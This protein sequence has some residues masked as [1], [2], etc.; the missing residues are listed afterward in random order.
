MKQYITYFLNYLQTE[1]DA[2]K[3]TIHKYRADLEKLFEYLKV[4][5]INEID[6]NNL[7]DYLNYIRQTYNYTASSIANKI[8]I[9]HPFFRFLH[10]YG[11]ININPSVFIRTP[12]K[13]VRLP[14]VFNDIVAEFLDL[15]I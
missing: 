8:N 1:K 10:N 3:S 15:I 14:K 6:Q 9:L 12:R 2:A 4:T 5:D 13:K 7:R 11:Y